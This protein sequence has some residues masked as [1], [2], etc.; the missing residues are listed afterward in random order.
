MSRDGR[1]GSRNR[2]ALAAALIALLSLG[3]AAPASAFTDAT[4]LGLVNDLGDAAFA[5]LG[6]I[7]VDVPE[8]RVSR[9]SCS[10][11]DDAA[12]P[13]CSGAKALELLTQSDR[14]SVAA[15]SDHSAADQRAR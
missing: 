8:D 14:G 5:G 13:K 6:R 12:E 11:P 7:T 15:P 1:V 2:T 10:D 3:A 9:N 4:G